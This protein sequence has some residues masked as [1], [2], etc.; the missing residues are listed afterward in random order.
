MSELRRSQNRIL[1]GAI[2]AS[3][4]LTPSAVLANGDNGTRTQLMDD[5]TVSQTFGSTMVFHFLPVNILPT[6]VDIAMGSIGKGA[7]YCAG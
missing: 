2:L 4:A 3:L 6:A 1:A 7:P 5:D